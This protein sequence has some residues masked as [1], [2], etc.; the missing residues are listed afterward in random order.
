MASA[1]GAVDPTSV[2][3]GAALATRFGT[4]AASVRPE[5]VFAETHGVGGTIAASVVEW[6]GDGV[7]DRRPA[8]GLRVSMADQ[9]DES[10]PRTLEG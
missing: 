5:E 1:G 10:I 8:G 9:R 2:D 7:A 4:M 6:F 3:S